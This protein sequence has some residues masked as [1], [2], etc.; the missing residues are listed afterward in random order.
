MNREVKKSFSCFIDFIYL[1]NVLKSFN[2]FSFPITIE[3]LSHC[4]NNHPYIFEHR[5]NLFI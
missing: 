1:Q 5:S 4:M 2:R 3:I